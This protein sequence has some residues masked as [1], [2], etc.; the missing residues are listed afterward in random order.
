MLRKFS[1][2]PVLDMTTMSWKTSG[3]VWT[4][5]PYFDCKGDEVAEQQEQQTANF[6]SQLMQIFN[7]QYS[8]QQQVLTYL[9]G[10]LQPMID[11]P[12]GYS[13]D[14][15]AAQRTSATDTLSAE[16]QNAQKALQNTEFSQGSRDLPSGVNDQLNEAL[17][18]GEAS[19]KANA[20]NTITTN[21]AA[22]EQS[23]YWNALSALN[24]QA[25]TAYNPLGYAGAAT[26]GANAVTGL[27]QAVTASQGPSIGSILGGIAGA[28]VGALGA[29]LGKAGSFGALFGCWIAAAHFD[30]WNDPRTKAV[31]RYL[32][33][34]F[35]AHWYGRMTMKV[36]RQY[37]EWI[38]SKQ[39]LVNMLGPLFDLALEQARA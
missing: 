31:R 28:G 29:G 6:N 35:C 8:S 19:D 18:Q 30:G 15:L 33:T 4:N 5:E 26:S 24:G 9:Q 3:F 20:Q 25:T 13:P 10:K 11:N 12:T 2:N 32:N 27:S 38:A 17:L 1:V 7:K 14:A 23:N 36:Y 22:L 21:N 37:G 34:T 39:I 16:Y